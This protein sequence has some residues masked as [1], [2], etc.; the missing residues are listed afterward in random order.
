MCNLQNT[1][2]ILA[3][4]AEFDDRLVIT[5][6]KH[7]TRDVPVRERSPV[8]LEPPTPGSSWIHWC[9]LASQEAVP[10]LPGPNLASC[11][12]VASPGLSITAAKQMALAEFSSPLLSKSSNL[13]VLLLPSQKWPPSLTG[14]YLFLTYKA[15]FA[16]TEVDWQAQ[17]FL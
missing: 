17:T 8:L 5:S 7:R 3:G 6:V 1:L 13:C 10:A 2:T 11:W 9:T 12:W 15:F 14:M 16:L 4:K